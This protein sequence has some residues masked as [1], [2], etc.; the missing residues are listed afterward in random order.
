[1]MRKLGWI[2]I[3]AY[4]IDTAVSLIASVIP[5]VEELSNIISFPVSLVSIV[6]FVLACMGKFKPQK[7]F[8]ILSGFSLLLTGFGIVIGLRL[9]ASLGASM[10]SQEITLTF[11]RGQFAWYGTVHWILMISA[12]LV[13]AFGFH[14]YLKAQSIITHDGTESREPRPS[15]KKHLKK[16]LIS[17]AV[18]VVLGIGALVVAF[19]IASRD[20]PPQDATDLIPERVEPPP[21][22]N[23]YTHFVSVTDSIYWPKNA[24]ASVSSYL[25]GKPADEAVIQQIITR[26]TASLQAIQQGL[27]C[28]VCVTPKVTGFDT[29]IPYINPWLNMS[30]VMALKT[31]HDRL[32]GR[33]TEASNTCITLLQFGDMIQKEGGCT[34][35]YLVGNTVIGIGLTQA[36]DLAR[37][38]GIP[39]GELTRLSE[40]LAA[41]GTFDRGLVHAMKVEYTV[42]AATVDQIRDGKFNQSELPTLAD[43]KTNLTSKG[44]RISGYFFQPNK[45]KLIC[46]N[47]SRYMIKNAPLCYADVKRSGVAE[48][49][50]MN[51]SKVSLIA[52]PNAIG[53]IL[54]KLAIPNLD[55]LLENRCR[56]QC[57]VSATRLIVA[58]NAYQKKEGKLP[59]NLQSLVPAYLTAVPLDPYDGKPFRYLPSRGIIYSVGK[60][61]KDSGGSSKAPAD[62]KGDTPAQMRWK[63]E[64][65]VFQIS[66]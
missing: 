27:Q 44:R 63:T 53:R 1:M 29:K 42:D 12:V 28:R 6:V 50:E 34:I 45:T 22:Q 62:A 16:I 35:G 43:G 14:T 33:Y 51:V 21:E 55:G 19:K 58:C 66:D 64:D 41:L 17:L 49:S 39:Q 23:A 54:C 13:S 3:G 61:L 20:I 25:D 37:D 32:A 9:Y 2:Y 48:V 18:L 59:D 56:T 26:N 57:F 7:T 38:K 10:A 40:A 4:C 24:S 65:V 5:R 46:A 30:K 36:Q 11:L 52:Q 15:E 60:D 47:F 8:L 31:R